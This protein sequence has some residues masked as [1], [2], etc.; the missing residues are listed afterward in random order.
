MFGPVQLA[1]VGSQESPQLAWGAE[2][3][4][5]EFRHVDAGGEEQLS[6][7]GDALSC[8]VGQVAVPHEQRGRCVY[9]G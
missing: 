6:A 2:R 4:I 7:V 1:V 5:G 9:G 3:V 8:R